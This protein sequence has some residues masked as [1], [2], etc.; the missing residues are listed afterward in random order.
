MNS[1]VLTSIAT[2][3]GIV[4]GGTGVYWTLKDRMTEEISN[5]VRMQTKIARIEERVKQLESQLWT[6]QTTTRTN[7]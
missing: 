3:L 1:T 2:A 7:E 4:V 5:Q 6:I